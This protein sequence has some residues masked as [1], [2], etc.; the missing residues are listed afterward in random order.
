MNKLT[1]GLLA[2]VVAAAIAGAASAQTFSGNILDASATWNADFTSLPDRYFFFD[3]SHVDETYSGTGLSSA[4]TLDLD[5][6]Y[7]QNSS[8]ELGFTVSLNGTDVGT[9]SIPAGVGGPSEANLAYSFAPIA[10]DPG[11]TFT[12]GLRVTEPVCVGCGNVDLN[13]TFGSTV[14]ISGA[15]GV[16]EPAAWAI[17]L[18]GFAGM[19]AALRR[20]KAALAA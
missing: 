18:T 6:F 13:E 4:S 17:M 5:I 15:G 8:Q 9:W 12:V 1:I 14:S 2:G 11:D 3:G 7:S 16:P 10:A 19:G 20:R